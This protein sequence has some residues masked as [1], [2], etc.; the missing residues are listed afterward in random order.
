MR[1][2]AAPPKINCPHCG[3]V[4]TIRTSRPVSRITRELYCQCVSLVE[5]A[6][7]L[8]QPPRPRGGPPACRRTEPVA[9]A[10]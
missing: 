3:S 7:T 4:A 1:L 9:H 5:V 10:A 8:S 6:R 2:V